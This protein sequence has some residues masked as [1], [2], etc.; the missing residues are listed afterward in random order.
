MTRIVS[1]MYLP[2]EAALEKLN[3]ADAEFLHSARARGIY[4]AGPTT[5]HCLISLASAEINLERQVENQQR[6]VETTRL[7][8]DGV[9]VMLGHAA[10]LGRGLK[11][12]ADSFA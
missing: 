11:A 5:L 3:R 8:L 12:A 4:L 6:I 1:V 2:N 7:L 10:A 9:A